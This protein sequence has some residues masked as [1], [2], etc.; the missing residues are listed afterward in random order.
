VTA[1]R[2]EISHDRIS[3]ADIDRLQAGPCRHHV[4][5]FERCVA[6][7]EVVDQPGEGNARIAERVGALAFGDHAAVLMA[8]DRVI[9]Q[10]DRA[11]VRHLA[12]EDEPVGEGIVGGDRRRAD[13][14]EHLEARIG[15]LDGEIHPGDR[16]AD[17]IHRVVAAAR[18]Q[19]LRHLEGE[20]GFGDAHMHVLRRTMRP[21]GQDE[22]AE[23]PAGKRLGDADMLLTDGAGGGDLPAVD[24]LRGNGD[25]R[26]LDIIALGQGGGAELRRQMVHP[27]LLAPGAPEGF[28]SAAQV[29]LIHSLAPSLGTLL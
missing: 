8:A 15:Y 28:G 19:R 16:V 5:G 7:R 17:F 26:V 1:K 22:V 6:P 11:P 9:G 20:L 18:G 2:S 4:P 29:V 13:R 23:Q 10:I 3:G 27:A 12:A 25:H 24:R 14:V 21:V